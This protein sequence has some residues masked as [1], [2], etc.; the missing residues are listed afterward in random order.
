MKNTFGI[1]TVV[2]VAAT[3]M[4]GQVSFAQPGNNTGS[5]NSNRTTTSTTRT[6]EPRNDSPDLGWLGL[7]GL[8]GLAGLLKKPERQVVHQTDVRTTPPH[9]PNTPNR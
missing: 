2:A 6:E 9:N 4:L 3:M 1:S 5:N 8:A 7:L